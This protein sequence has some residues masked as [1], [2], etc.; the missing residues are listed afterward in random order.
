MSIDA[1]AG[2]LV[3]EDAPVLDYF[4]SCSAQVTNPPDRCCAS[5][6][7]DFLT[8]CLHATTGNP[9]RGLSHALCQLARLERPPLSE[10]SRTASRKAID[11]GAAFKHPPRFRAA[12]RCR[13]WLRSAAKGRARCKLRR[14]REARFATACT[15]RCC[16]DRTRAAAR[17]VRAVVARRGLRTQ[18]HSDPRASTLA[19]DIVVECATRRV[20][21]TDFAGTGGLLQRAASIHGWHHAMHPRFDAATDVTAEQALAPQQG[22]DRRHRLH[23]VDACSVIAQSYHP[24]ADLRGRGALRRSS[25]THTSPGTVSQYWRHGVEDV[26][27]GAKR[28]LRR[29]RSPSPK[30][31]SRST[32]HTGSDQVAPTRRRSPDRSADC[33][34]T[35]DRLP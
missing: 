21:R 27:R 28:A 25:L 26:E 29:P 5:T 16:S 14:G 1:L 9:L 3:Q 12:H 2:L 33:L 11:R 8:T 13:D 22:R 23:H 31:G 10:E 15:S 35:A 34:L 19:A 17:S 4:I 32:A 20:S 7:C 6:W 18:L 30:P 24:R